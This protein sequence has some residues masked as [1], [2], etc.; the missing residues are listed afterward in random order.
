MPTRDARLLPSLRR[1]LF[2]VAFVTWIAACSGAAGASLL[3]SPR[4]AHEH[5]PAW[6]SPG[7]VSLAG[8][9]RVALVAPIPGARITSPYGWRIHPVL[10]YRRFHKGV[11]YGAPR[12]TPVRAA[13]DGV[14]EAM[15]RDSHRGIYLRV[16]HAGGVETRYAHLSRFA[17][18]LRRGTRVRSGEVIAAVGST[19]WST[20]PHLFY[21]VLI[22][23]RNVDPELIPAHAPAP[24]VE[25]ERSLH[26]IK[27]RAPLES[28]ALP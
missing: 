4:A 18:G 24:A 9:V 11:D 14:V 21:E 22:D 15:G 23:G 12:G 1:T 25:W 10:K 26:L 6:W 17:P 20:G 19:G 2:K 8:S 5:A 13:Q 16:R 7:V 27:V 3:S 28:S